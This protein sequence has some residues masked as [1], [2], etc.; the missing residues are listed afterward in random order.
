MINA[1]RPPS[2]ASILLRKI[3]A[4]WAQS[5]TSLNIT[6]ELKPDSNVCS[7]RAKC[8]VRITNRW[9]HIVY[10]QIL[11]AYENKLEIWWAKNLICMLIY[12]HFQDSNQ[13]WTPWKR[14]WTRTVKS[15]TFKASNIKTSTST[16]PPHHSS[17]IASQTCRASMPSSLQSANSAHVPRSKCEFSKKTLRP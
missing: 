5:R 7:P 12:I 6:P 16:L 1:N 8:H 3:D 10:V 2:R 15:S 13:P 14:R 17:K 4:L 9:W 11:P